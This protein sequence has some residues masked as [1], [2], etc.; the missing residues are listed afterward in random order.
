MNTL[1]LR[2]ICFG[3]MSHIVLSMLCEANYLVTPIIVPYIQ[4]F[5]VSIREDGPLQ[6]GYT[7]A[8]GMVPWV[9]SVD[10][11]FSSTGCASTTLKIRPQNQFRFT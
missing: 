3:L 2:G 6:R 7:K 4:R 10:R 9:G 1:Y 8:G 11:F 5:K